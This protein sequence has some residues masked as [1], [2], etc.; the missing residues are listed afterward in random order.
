MSLFYLYIYPPDSKKT[1]ESANTWNKQLPQHSDG[2]SKLGPEKRIPKTWC[3]LKK[4]VSDLVSSYF[5]PK[6]IV[7][8]KKKQKKVVTS[9]RSRISHFSFQPHSDL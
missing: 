7:I 6:I 5:S 3:S 4:K 9:N 2:Y 1:D 8:S